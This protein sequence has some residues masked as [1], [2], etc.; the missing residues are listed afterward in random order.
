MN[1]ENGGISFLGTLQV[2]FITLRLCGAINWTWFW[3]MTPMWGYILDSFI[4]KLLEDK[5]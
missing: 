4:N 5:K 1:K 3:V 2:A